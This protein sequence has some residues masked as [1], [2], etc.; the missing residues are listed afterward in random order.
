M[1]GFW[2]IFFLLVVLKIPVL[3]SIWLVWWA[4]QATPEPAEGAAEDSDGGFKRRPPRPK[5]PR[6]PR[7]GPHGGGAALP[8]PPLPARRAHQGR[9]AGCRS[10]LSLARDRRMY[11]WKSTSIVCRLEA[12]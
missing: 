2:P 5:L 3:G 6:G 8:L 11:G 9:Q 4:S 7:R 10:P 1:T 12:T